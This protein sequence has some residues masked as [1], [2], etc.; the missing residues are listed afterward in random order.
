MGGE[1]GFRYVRERELTCTE[2]DREGGSGGGEG[3]GEE[4]RLERNE[5]GIEEVTAGRCRE[6]FVGEGLVPGELG[7]SSERD[8]RKP[9]GRQKDR[10]EGEE[11]IGVDVGGERR[12]TVSVRPEA[13][14]EEEKDRW[15]GGSLTEGVGEEGGSEMEREG[16]EMETS[17]S[18]GSR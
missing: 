6:R 10:P 9:D 8:S 7:R 2:M 5:G 12:W 13:E 14:E 1:R 18:R 4:G 15:R 3:D 16:R 17:G 11:M